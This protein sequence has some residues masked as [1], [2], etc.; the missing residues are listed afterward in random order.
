NI[1]AAADAVDARFTIQIPVKA[2]PR[3]ISVAFLEE[4][5]A[6]G[7]LRL[8]PFIRSSNDTLDATGHPHVERVIVTGPFNA[9]GPGDTPSRRQ[10]FTCRP[11]SASDEEACARRIVSTLA[12]RAYRGTESP[13]DLKR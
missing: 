7:G 13:N 3:S 5:P 12:H 1:T 11:A 2:G 10:I 8:Q 9:T 6:Q 4:S